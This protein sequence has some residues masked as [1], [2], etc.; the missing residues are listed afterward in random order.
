M[1]KDSHF[2]GLENK[3]ELRILMLEDSEDDEMLV[4]YE[5]E[6]LREPYFLKRVYKQETFIDALENFNPDIIL[7]DYNLPAFNGHEALELKQFYSHEI[8]P[9]LFVTGFLGEEK[10]VELIKKGANDF[11][12]KDNLSRLPYAILNA[13][14]ESREKRKRIEYEVASR[15]SEAKYRHLLEQAADGI[16]VGDSNSRFLEVNTKA[17]EILGYT[18]EELL[19]MQVEDLVPSGTTFPKFDDLPQGKVHRYE[20]IRKKKDGTVFPVELS[21]TRTSFGFYQEIMRDISRRKRVEKALNNALKRLE[22]HVE[23]SPLAILEFNR[24]GIISRWTE[25]AEKLF[26]WSEKEA[27]GKHLSA[28]KLLEPQDLERV[29]QVYTAKLEQQVTNFTYVNHAYT[30]E[31]KKVYC[32]W[33]NSVSLDDKGEPE[34]ILSLVNDVTVRKVTE[35]ANWEGQMQERK[36]IAREIHEGIGQLLVATKFKLASIEAGDGFENKISETEDLLEKSIEEVR[37]IS[38]NM[39]PR[40]VEQLGIENA[41]RQLAEQ[42]QRLTGIEIVFH[43]VGQGRKADNTILA[44]VYRLAQESLNNVIKH[45]RA[46]GVLIEFQQSAHEI[47][48]SIEDNG[49]GFNIN[50][51]ESCTGGLGNMKERINALGGTFHLTSGIGAGT[52][53]KV[54][55]PVVKEFLDPEMS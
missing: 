1:D 37:R 25:Q 12:L 54:K 55:I 20:T 32:E 46:S 2:N 4:R 17:C 49:N 14:R 6:K 11:I 22:F 3:K 18:K 24:K 34:S 10:A 52:Q 42:V 27:L 19:R 30:K 47:L 21:V 7:S 13:L 44:S 23:N 51:E 53:I 39:A 8:I 50:I 26:G 31:G 28:L 41:I 45:S 15:R 36:R 35:E 48:F 29:R 43:Y 40:S 38:L 5:L 16:F 33:Y 9:V